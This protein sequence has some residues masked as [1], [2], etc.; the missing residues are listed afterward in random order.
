M[1]KKSRHKSKPKPPPDNGGSS[2]TGTA[3]F[4]PPNGDV[5]LGVSS[6]WGKVASFQTAA[7]ISTQPAIWNDYTEADGSFAWILNDVKQRPAVTPMVSWNLP[8]TG[9]QVSNGSKDSYIKAQAALVKSFGG[10]VF[11]RLDWEMNGSWY[12]QY[13]QPGVSPAEFVAS[14]RHVYDVFHAAGVRNAAFVWCPN[15]YAGGNSDQVSLWYPGNGYVDWM[16][17]DA[18]PQSTQESFLLTGK[19]GLDAMASFASSHG[20]PLMLAEWAAT[21]KPV[22]T[23]SDAAAI[24]LVFSWAK[25][26]PR[27][28]KALVYFNYVTQG[29]DFTL[30]AHA[31]AAAAFRSLTV[32]KQNFLLRV[33]GS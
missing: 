4:E 12:P 24:D 22:S 3:L 6:D 10:P 18:Y 16:G 19:G 17:L 33:P 14:W 31:S 13:S 21:T 1:I 29:Q 30:A 5:Y 28:V 11:I 23:L 8:L 26:Y 9:S 7:G 20:K 15:T 32:G 2:A 27:T 25:K